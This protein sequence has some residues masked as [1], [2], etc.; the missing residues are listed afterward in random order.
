MK[1]N[2]YPSVQEEIIMN[3]TIKIKYRPGFLFRLSK[4]ESYL[5]TMRKNGWELINIKFG[6]LLYFKKCKA[7]EKYYYITQFAN[8]GTAEYKVGIRAL[9]KEFRD[10][11]IGN[12]ACLQTKL[13]GFY[14]LRYTV[15]CF[16]EE[17]KEKV[18]SALELRKKDLRISMFIIFEYFMVN[19]ICVPLALFF[20]IR[21]CL[22]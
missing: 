4:S 8:M 20:I 16:S 1:N 22:K 19:F 7:A 17:D 9:A 2:L 12:R 5:N 14:A 3:E 6:C 21:M 18:K 11:Y 10:S 13:I 15:Y